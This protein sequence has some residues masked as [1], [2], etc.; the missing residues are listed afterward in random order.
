MLR[1]DLLE[2]N[3]LRM[4]G[5]LAEGCREEVET[6]V[7]SHETIPDMVVNLSEVTYIDWAGEEVLCWLGQR[8]VRFTANNSYPLHI[9]ERLH[10]KMADSRSPSPPHKTHSGSCLHG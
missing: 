4:S 2:S 7:G 10:L 8:G 5:R 6:F 9:C 3:L 1:I